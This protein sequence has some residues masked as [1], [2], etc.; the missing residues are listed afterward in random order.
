MSAPVQGAAEQSLMGLLKPAPIPNQY[1]PAIANLQGGQ[2]KD[3]AA[4]QYGEQERKLREALANKSISMGEY[5]SLMSQLQRNRVG[6]EQAAYREPAIE[7][8]KFG[9][10]FG[11][12]ER[13]VGN[14]SQSIALAAL[15]AIM[16]QLFGRQS[17]YANML[18][19]APYKGTDYSGID[20]PGLAGGWQ[21]PAM[22][23]ASQGMGLPGVNWF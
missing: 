7:Q 10:N 18:G 12:Q 6:A 14:Q 2:A 3:V 13:E 11:L 9:A 1:T 5:M 4:A 23:A 19:N 22:T 17:A 20:R 16:G 15:Q 21:N 8:A